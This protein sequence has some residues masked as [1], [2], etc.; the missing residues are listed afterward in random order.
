MIQLNNHQNMILRYNHKKLWNQV[1]HYVCHRYIL[2]DNLLN[3]RQC[4]IY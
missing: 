2:H 4:F 3:N 1:H